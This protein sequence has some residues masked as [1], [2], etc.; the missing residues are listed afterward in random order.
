MTARRLLRGAAVALAPAL[1][2]LGLH[3]RALDYEFVWTDEGEITGQGSLVRPPDRIL[4]AFAEPMHGELGFQ[5]QGVRQ[6]Y[7]RPLQVAIVSAVHAAAGSLP[8]AFR[9]VSLALGAA[10]AALFALFAWRLLGRAGPALFAGAV[11]AAHPAT[12]EVHVWIA[13]LSAALV[14]LFVVAALAAAREALRARGRAGFAFGAAVSVAALVLGLLS[15]ESAAVVPGLALALAL[16]VLA[17]GRAGGERGAALRRTALRAGWLVG[18][19]GAVVALYVFAWR[20]FVLGGALT[21]A[22]P[23]GG[24]PVSHALSTLALWPEVLGWLVAPWLS[25]TG[26]VVPIV[27]SLLEPRVWLGLALPLASLAVWLG[28]LRRG[29]GAASLGLAWVW[30]AYLPA[31]GVVPLLHARSERD[32][33]LPV[34]GA[35]LLLA[36]AGVALARR[37]PPRARLAV[38]VLG[39]CFVGFLS[40]RTWARTPEWRSTL[41]LFQAD[42]AREPLHR[43][44]RFLV[45][46]ELLEAERPEEARR[47][48]D[49]L[50]AQRALFE[51][52]TSYLRAA[53]VHLLAC[54]VNQALGR[55]EDTLRLYREAGRPSLARMRG[56]HYCRGR[57]LLRLGRPDEALEVYQGLDALTPEV[58][59]PAFTV[60]IAR[61]HAMA[62]RPQAA[63]AALGRIDRQ[64][65]QDRWLEEEIIAVNRLLAR[66]QRRAGPA[67]H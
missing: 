48:L 55:D 28:L 5:L 19:Q 33:Y 64:R 20:P 57:A 36:A 21:G 46:V 40:E 18:V 11:A 10:T 31:S 3:L 47:H 9:A 12:V 34:L 59:E 49:E 27:D 52:R 35:A 51:D 1:L 26:V 7:Y 30:L 37:L 38:P 32:L 41:T 24:G 50:L 60:A 2:F 22:A 62:G 13:G 54:R 58:R 65:V 39:L 15:K 63:R 8:R 61:S 6:S 16:G 66:V 14:A 25:S 45:A 29:A 44:A 56:F 53:D 42:L 67:P 43:E 17:A 23:I 4:A